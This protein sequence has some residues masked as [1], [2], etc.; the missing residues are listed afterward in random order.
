MCLL[1]A[2]HPS[3]TDILLENLGYE[4]KISTSNVMLLTI[5]LDLSGCAAFCG[6][7]YTG[8]KPRF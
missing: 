1:C 2:Y 7:D 5:G 8:Y 6:L 3:N 4:L